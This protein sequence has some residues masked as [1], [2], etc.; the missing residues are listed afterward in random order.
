MANKEKN[1]GQA[2][3]MIERAQRLGGGEEFWYRSTLTLADTILSTEKEGK[4]GM[5]R[6]GQRC[7]QQGGPRAGAPLTP[8]CAPQAC[9][10][11]Q[12]LIEVFKVLKRQRPNRA[13]VLEFMAT[14]LEAR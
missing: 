12:K 14:D 4:E 8:V 1:Y 6:R 7:A 9:Q 11:F 10:L 13:P 2:R 3:K 5:V